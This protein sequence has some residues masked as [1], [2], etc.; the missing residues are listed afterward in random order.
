[1]LK[2]NNKMTFNI[3][4]ILFGVGFLLVVVQ[5]FVEFDKYVKG[6]IKYV[7]MACFVIG[8]IL[9]FLVSRKN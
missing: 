3:A 8:L 9:Y 6:L 2:S 1:M 4:N 5:E 7:V